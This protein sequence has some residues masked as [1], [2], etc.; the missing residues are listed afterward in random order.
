MAHAVSAHDPAVSG[1]AVSGRVIDSV[2]RSIAEMHVGLW[3]ILDQHTDASRSLDSSLP[4]KPLLSTRT[5]RSGYFVLQAPSKGLWKF[6]IG[7][8]K[9]RALL[10]RRIL[11]VDSRD[12]G[13]ISLPETHEV[14]LRVLGSDGQ[15]LS[16]RL[17][18]APSDLAGNPR[19]TAGLPIQPIEGWVQEARFETTDDDGRA[20]LLLDERTWTLEVSAPRHV[21]L[22][23][24]LDPGESKRTLRLDPGVERLIR[25]GHSAKRPVEGAL[26]YRLGGLAPLAR[27]N[28]EGAARVTL[29]AS[30]NQRL[31]VSTLGGQ[32][33]QHVVAATRSSETADSQ[34]SRTTASGEVTIL[35]P[36]PDLRRGYTAATEGG[37]PLEGVHVFELSNPGRSFEGESADSFSVPSCRLSFL[38]A[39]APERAVSVLSLTACS[40]EPFMFPIAK[41]RSLAGRVVDSEGF[42]LAG[43]TIE[44]AMEKLD[45][46]LLTRGLD[47]RRRLTSSKEGHFQFSLL[48]PDQEIVL[49]ASEDG[50][51]PV[52]ITID[53]LYDSRD[54][55]LVVLRP[56]LRGKGLVTNTDLIPIADAQ[57]EVRPAGT[58]AHEVAL[59]AEDLAR[60]NTDSKGQFE[61]EGLS[62][63]EVDLEVS[64]PGFAAIIVRGIG[65]DP[66]NASDEGVVD[67][68]TVLLGPGVSVEG[69]VVD[70]DGQ[71]LAEAEV[72]LFVPQ[73][74]T[75]GFR[76]DLHETPRHRTSSRSDGRFVIPDLRPDEPYELRASREGYQSVSAGLVTPPSRGL[77]LKLRPSARIVGTVRDQD[78]EPV[79]GA[80]V[81]GWTNK[82]GAYSMST[83]LGPRPRTKTD[84]DGRFEVDG[85]EGGSVGLTVASGEHQT[86]HL[87]GLDV[88]PG[89]VLEIDIEIEK[90][91]FLRGT[92]RSSKGQPLPDVWISLVNPDSPQSFVAR[93]KTDG[94]GQYEFRT[95]PSG[96]FDLVATSPT[97]RKVSKSILLEE[98]EQTTDLDFPPGVV[99]RGLIFD[100][101]RNPVRGAIVDL[102]ATDSEPSTARDRVRS[103]VEGRFVFDEVSP[104]SY[105]VSVARAGFA[106]H[107]QVVEVGAE[108]IGDLEIVLDPGASLVGRVLGTRDTELHQ[109]EIRVLGLPRQGPRL[110][111]GYDGGYRI[112]NLPT[113]EIEIEAVIPATGR[114][115]RDTVEIPE[116]VGEVRHDLVFGEGYT[117]TGRVRYGGKPSSQGMVFFSALDSQ[118][119]GQAPLDG[120]GLFRLENLRQGKYRLDVVD[121]KTGARHSRELDVA[122]DEH[123][124]IDIV[125]ARLAGWVR[126]T[127]GSGL[128][129]VAIYLKRVDRA[130]SSPEQRG[131]TD[132]RGFFDLGQVENGSWQLTA[133][134]PS[135]AP[136]ETPIY[137]EAGRD[138]DD[139]E[140]LL[141]RIDP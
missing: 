114:T 70:Q 89:E 25:I 134:E 133:L 82:G 22:W 81:I 49:L 118:F 1:P 5:D 6:E 21:S 67:L 58:S 131:I 43:V 23:V 90:G 135:H 124:R 34:M 68:G 40:S 129:R 18:L 56:A 126:D 4:S 123:L 112:D 20:T 107:S 136:Y 64:K 16:A 47:G 62:I 32:E 8:E 92:V 29:P 46:A 128:A 93:T 35:L 71:P 111:P 98:G 63:G 117:V 75:A 79:G 38:S 41:G 88:P 104:G 51:V 36:S 30:K 17:A 94:V 42:P 127:S 13:D 119:A 44:L 116:G 138:I 137:I 74:V 10:G 84:R 73:D 97:G 95:L 122:G 77:E 12:L 141:R 69:I 113:G 85:L 27:T 86:L 60:S 99:I 100:G 125:G 33:V 7:Q 28:A 31:I 91:I 45:R 37:R 65:V 102:V 66:G 54:D 72:G 110:H 80:I 59:E 14:E 19:R 57:I 109:V 76:K 3:P 61:V 103:D 15:P 96:R 101:S 106:P 87:S 24:E 105:Q 2:G 52:R 115:V 39:L 26:V 130:D 120:E 78:G 83:L 53:G 48:P 108:P 50:Y 11:L 9:G 139:L 121:H 132:S 55:L 140:I